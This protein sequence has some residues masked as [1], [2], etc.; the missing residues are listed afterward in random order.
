MRVM[1]WEEGGSADLLPAP[2]IV[3]RACQR[4]RFQT[5][6]RQPLRAP[7]LESLFEF[8]GLEKVAA[9]AYSAQRSAERTWLGPGKAVRG[10]NSPSK[11]GEHGDISG[12]QL[13]LSTSGHK[14]N[15]TS[16]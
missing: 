11:D 9:R 4:S 14:K 13:D 7:T 1:I 12:S 3:H 2:R 5:R 16:L 8:G 6:A 10:Q 15:K